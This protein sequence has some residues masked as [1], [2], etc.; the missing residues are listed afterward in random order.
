[1]KIR[2][3][4]MCR[5]LC[6]ALCL[7]MVLVIPLVTKA[8]TCE[9]L[10]TDKKDG[11]CDVCGYLM[12]D[13]YLGYITASLEGNIAVNYFMLLSDAVLA[14]E[15][16][17]MEFT[18]ADGEIIKVPVSQ[19]KLI[20][21]YD[22]FTCEVAAKE[23]TDII[24]GQFYY[25]GQPVF[26]EAHQYNVRAYAKHIIQNSDD[27]NAKALME[28]MV[29]YGAASQLHFGYN[30]GDLA[31]NVRD[32]EDNLL[33]TV[34][35]YENIHITEY[36]FAR[37][38]GTDKVKLY[39]A[40]LILNSETTLRLFFNGSI[41]ATHEGKDLKVRQRGGLYYVDI[42]NIA[43]KDLDDDVTITI[44]DGTNSANITF[45]P[46]SYCQIVEQEDTGA[47][48]E[49]MRNLAIALYLYN[50]A[51]GAYFVD[52]GPQGIG[53]TT[54][55]HNLNG[56]SGSI[57]GQVTSVTFGR[58]NQYRDIVGSYEGTLVDVEQDAPAYAYYVPNNSGYDVYVLSNDVI[59][60]PTNSTK[61]FGN[62]N[63]LT[64]V[65]TD[66][67]DMSRVTNAYQMF[68]KCY[69]LEEIDVSDWDTSKITDMTAIFYMCRS[70]TTIPGI[71]KWDT[72]SCTNLY[73]AFFKMD[74]LES[75]NLAGWDVSK[76]TNL[77]RAIYGNPKLNYLNITGWNI[78]SACNA[79]SAFA[80]NPVLAKI[81]ATGLKITGACNATNAFAS[82][83]VLPK[84]DA[85]GWNI[86]GITNATEMFYGCH[87]LTEVT[88]SG[89]WQLPNVTVLTGMF[90]DCVALESIDV[91]GWDMR[92][93]N[94]TSYMFYHC[95]SLTALNGIGQWQFEN[96]RD[97][98]AMFSRCTSLVELDIA[99]WNMSKVEKFDS[100]FNFEHKSYP[101]MQLTTLDVSKWDTSS[102]TS[103]S[104]MFQG[105]CNLIELDV[106]NWNV[107]N[108][109]NFSYM[110]K[111]R[112]NVDNSMKLTELN[113]S[114]W[115]TSSAENME[116]MFQGCNKITKLDVSKWNMTNVKC[117]SH[118]FADCKSL[119]TLDL[120][121]WQ[122]PSM[123]YMDAML[124]NCDSLKSI[125]VSSFDTGNVKE[126]SQM[127][128]YCYLLETIEGLEKW[129]TSNGLCFAEMFN[130]CRSL[131]EL[132]LSSFDTSNA[133]QYFNY[134]YAGVIDDY[135]CFES[136][137]NDMHALT[138][139]TVGDGF[140]YDEAKVVK[141][142]YKPQ[143]PAPAAKTGFTAKWRN[144]DTGVLYSASEIPLG[145]AATYE[146]V[147]EEIPTT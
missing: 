146:V 129:D 28:A 56:N 142:N 94:N 63:I 118:M 101:D 134:H 147:Y 100:M 57:T 103:M 21:G 99:N 19:S 76:V 106:S 35:D 137:F 141:D 93:V 52:D 8:E 121:K 80:S 130:G 43:A 84:I 107:G 24:T 88:G 4:L 68:I 89:D 40:S 119:T 72:S 111:G 102:A 109:K 145:V 16:A 138:K 13:V 39:S 48:T 135:E 11:R 116:C 92:Q 61:L 41:T 50:K 29:N 55:L 2:S 44:N 10:D 7:C 58:S 45:N 17:C 123:V 22:V 31:D 49:E 9:H 69:A 18:M 46:L 91:S 136:M 70:L 5:L 115:D 34:P 32:K 126:F 38:Q 15:T 27:P 3:K 127:F 54:A 25:N 73:V 65:D 122:T 60:A 113:V 104:A 82:N 85:T 132:D 110:F 112:A 14:D 47:Y 36:P 64:S 23:M 144:V 20:D 66:N 53:L 77:D 42:V 87:S 6:L 71:E 114:E 37:G 30:T 133:N 95:E 74:A 96:L 62:M 83:P 59:Y 128:E 1:M 124:N 97:V 51:A 120:S 98:T 90:Q 105:C 33:I 139:L 81:D 79:S 75:L 67:L 117:V 78:A 131:T 12:Q 140:N 86:T 108:V 26:A 125:D 143:F